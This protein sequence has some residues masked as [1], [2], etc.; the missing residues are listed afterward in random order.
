MFIKN[1]VMHIWHQGFKLIN[2]DGHYKQK[3]GI[4][5]NECEKGYRLVLHDIMPVDESRVLRRNTAIS[6]VL[7]L[8]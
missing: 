3:D 7:A 2:N 5:R 4:F 8:I 6:Q 1:K